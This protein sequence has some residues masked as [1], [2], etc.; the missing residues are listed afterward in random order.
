MNLNVEKILIIGVGMIGASIALASKSKG[1]K[2]IGFDNNSEFLNNA[3]KNQIIDES[4][5]S[6]DEINSKNHIKDIDLIIIA[7]PPKQTLEVLNSLKELWNTDITITDTSSVKNHIQLKDV[8]NIILSHP[9]AGS[10]QSGLS[11]ADANLFQG[12]KNVLCNPFD[13]SKE[14]FDKVDNFWKNA[15]QMR[16]SLM[17]VSEHDL[18]FAM[19]SHLPHLV[20]YALIDSIRL[21][22]T[23]VG[24]NAGGGLKEFLRLSGSNP[25]MWSD[26][27]TLNRVDLIKA[28]AG[29]QVSLNNLLEL[30]SE[31]KQIPDIFSHLEFL[32]K[33]LDEIK[34]FKEDKF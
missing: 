13:S 34:S 12:K 3:V 20:S 29:M 10:D 27:F 23:D 32:N 11:A 4:I 8:S 15:L 30:I 21:S 18:V 17:T 25:E 31:T 19:T 6:L 33:E 5:D 2:V 28:L 16:T 22:N 24:D 7:V 26:I 9:I 14:H 1:I